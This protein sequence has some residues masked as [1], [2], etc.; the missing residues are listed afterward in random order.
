[1]V[2]PV[3]GDLFLV[4]KSHTAGDTALKNRVY[5]AT[6]A[7]MD[8]YAD[9]GN[10]LTLTQVA[11][12]TS[13]D[14]SERQIGLTAADISADG[15]MIVVK[16]LEEAWVWPRNTGQSVDSALSNNTPVYLP[17]ALG[18]TAMIGTGEAIAFALDGSKFYTVVENGNHYGYFN[19]VSTTTEVTKSFQDGVF[20]ASNYAGTRD[21]YISENNPTTN[22]DSLNTLVA[23][24]ED[25]GTTDK[26]ILIKWGNLNIPAGSTVQSASIRV[27]VTNMSVQSYELYQLR[28]DWDDGLATWTQYTG[29][30]S[31]QIAG[32]EGSNDRGSSAVGSIT[33]SATGFKTFNLNAAGIA[34]VQS[35]VDDPASNYGFIITDSSADD[36][37][38]ITSRESSTPDDRPKLT[39]V[40]N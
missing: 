8:A 20:P 37:L 2:D 36:G 21:T 14:N 28:R 39:I 6:K 16:N 9:T 1:M 25:P 13:I 12:V 24:G 10:V 5:K 11:L 15:S 27:K 31:W 23:D 7:Q 22:Y 26:S 30:A 32:A 19:K 17:L 33:T 34:L 35:W 4:M 3:T 40:Y 38:D 18:L 29:G